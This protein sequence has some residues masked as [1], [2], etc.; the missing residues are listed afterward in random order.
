MKT[1]EAQSIQW[2][3]LHIQLLGG[4]LLDDDFS[5]V[6][7]LEIANGE[8]MK[9]YFLKKMPSSFGRAWRVRQLGRQDSEEYHCLLWDGQGTSCTCKS[10]VYRGNCRHLKSLRLLLDRGMI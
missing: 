5:P 10:G 1:L 7:V 6:W 3:K 4:P 8:E 9:L 2:G